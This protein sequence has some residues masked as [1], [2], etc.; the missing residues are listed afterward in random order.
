MLE[1]LA[2]HLIEAFTNVVKTDSVNYF[3]HLH[4]S[5]IFSCTHLPLALS[6]IYST[7]ISTELYRKI[8]GEIPL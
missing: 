4:F 7:L 8:P 1:F 2:A 6:L 5:F 3:A